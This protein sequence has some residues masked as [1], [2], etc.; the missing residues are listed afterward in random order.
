[1]SLRVFLA[2]GLMLSTAVFAEEANRAPK[3]EED[4]AGEFTVELREPRCR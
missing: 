3:P 4:K 1:M 2:T